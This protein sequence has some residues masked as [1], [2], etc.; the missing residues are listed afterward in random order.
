MDEKIV[1]LS[2]SQWLPCS[3]TIWNLL[4]EMAILL[5]LVSSESVVEQVDVIVYNRNLKKRGSV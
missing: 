1:G 4:F 5:N 2:I 3:L